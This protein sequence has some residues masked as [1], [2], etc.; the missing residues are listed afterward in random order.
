M[1]EQTWRGDV[2]N[3]HTYEQ[4]NIKGGMIYNNKQTNKQITVGVWGGGEGQNVK[5]YKVSFLV[6][7]VWLAAHAKMLEICS[8]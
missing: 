1:N 3:I 7:A 5:C 6:L 8:L 4:T 2:Y